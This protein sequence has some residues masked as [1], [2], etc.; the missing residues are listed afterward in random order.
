MDLEG[1]DVPGF[2]SDLEPGEHLEE[3]L[4]ATVKA[5][6]ARCTIIYERGAPYLA[7]FYVGH[8][9]AP[10]VPS[11]YLHRFL[12]SD[13]PGFLHS[14]PWQTSNSLILTEGYREEWFAEGVNDVTDPERPKIEKRLW[15]PGEWVSIDQNRYHRVELIGKGAWTLFVAGPRADTWRFWE[16]ATNK[17]EI[18]TERNRRMSDETFIVSARAG[19]PDVQGLKIGRGGGQCGVRLARRRRPPPI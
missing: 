13:D 18:W 1:L 2:L 16:R 7:R 4:W 9:A 14:H 17:F 12:A 3:L 19:D 5:M 6:D 15:R 10:D 11:V 8:R